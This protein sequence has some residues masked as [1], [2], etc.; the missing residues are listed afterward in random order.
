MFLDAN[1]KPMAPYSSSQEDVHQTSN[2][3]S[4]W[5]SDE[6]DDN[7]NIGWTDGDDPCVNCDYYGYP[8]LN[9]HE[10]DCAECHATLFTCANCL[11]DRP[12]GMANPI[13]D[14]GAACHSCDHYG[15]PCI[16]CHA[17]D[18]IECNSTYTCVN[19]MQVRPDGYSNPL[20]PNF[21]E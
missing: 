15:Y 3:L 13:Y 4:G 17:R 14:H 21:I 20:L 16:N 6:Y 1:Y 5:D 11:H 7:W 10:R 18:C 9:C 19:C 2:I 8:C 12:D